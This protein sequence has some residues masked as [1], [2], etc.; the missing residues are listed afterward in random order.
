MIRL[1]PKLLKTAL[2]GWWNDRALSLGAAISFYTLFSMAPA[3]LIVVSVAGLIY[4][5]DAAQGAIVNEIGG[6]IG[7]EPAAAIEAMIASASDF[8]SSVVGT[9][10]G[11][12]IFL[13]LATGA[14][15][16]LQD[17]LNIIWKAPPPQK[18]TIIVLLR[19]RLLSLTL[20]VAIGFVLLVSLILDAGL[21]ALIAYVPNVLP[22]SEALVFILNS[23]FALG[24]A[25]LLFALIFKV[26]PDVAIGWRDVMVGAILTGFLFTLGKFL[27]GLYIGRSGVAS[28][29]G[30]AGSLVT[31]LIWI[32]YSSQILLFGAEFTK[33]FAD[34]RRKGAEPE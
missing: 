27:I 25:S 13:F 31:I 5:R 22:R 7:T 32:Y 14:L 1:V 11:F 16:E 4:G 24:M 30:A 18:S 17:D 3:L 33:A 10:V 20:V 21:S 12:T 15:V 19:T 23:A 9:I 2:A 8:G 34:H 6:L 28:S 26:L 29:Y